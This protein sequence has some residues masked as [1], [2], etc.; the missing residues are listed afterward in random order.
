MENIFSMKIHIQRTH[1]PHISIQ[2]IPKT[3]GLIR[4]YFVFYPGSNHF[5]YL[6]DGNRGSNNQSVL[7]YRSKRKLDYKSPAL[8]RVLFERIRK[9]GVFNHI[10]LKDYNGVVIQFGYGMAPIEDVFM[11]IKGI[12]V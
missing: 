1:K 9:K 4:N 8:Y 2:F 11:F 5:Y 10:N 12:L 6:F 7:L 3:T